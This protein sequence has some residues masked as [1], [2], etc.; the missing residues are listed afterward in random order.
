MKRKYFFAALAFLI[1]GSGAVWLFHQPENANPEEAENKLQSIK[2]A[3]E[4]EFERTKDPALGYPPIERLLVAL[5]QTKARQAK[6]SGNMTRGPISSP[7]WHERGP[8]N[9]GGRTRVILI[10]KNDPT[11]RTIWAGGVAGGLW[12]TTDI[13]A[14]PVQWEKINDY[15][16]NMAIGAMAQDPN[17]PQIMYVGTGEGYGNWDAVQGLGLFKSTNGGA[18][19]QLLPSTTNGSF[20]QSRELIVTPQG[21]VYVCTNKG[22]HRSKDGGNTWE[23]VLGATLQGSDQTYDIVYSSNGAITA[24]TINSVYRSFTGDPNDWVK[25]SKS[26]VP[27]GLDR[28]E[29][30]VCPSDPNVIYGIGAINGGASVAFVTYD[31]GDTWFQRARPENNNGNEFTNGQAWYDL[32]IAVNPSNCEDVIT[33]GVPIRRSLD[34]ANTWQPFGQGI[35][36]DQ[37]VTVFDEEDPNRIYFGCDGGIYRV[38][39][40]N[41]VPRVEDKNFGYNVTQYYACAMHPDAYSDYFLGGTQ[42]NGSHQLNAWGITSAR[43]VWG[44]DGFMAH[45]DQNDPQIQLVSSQY[46][47]WG[48]SYNGGQSFGEGQGVNGGFFNPSDYD[49]DAKILY[50]ETNDGDFYRWKIDQALLELVD[51]GSMGSLNISHIRVDE[52]TPNRIYIG[53]NGGQVIRVDNADTGDQVVGTVLGT[54]GGNISSIDIEMGNPDHILITFSNY[55][56][57]NNIYE[58]KNGGQNWQGVEGSAVPNNL[59]DMPVRWGIFNP[60]DATQ[61]MIATEAGVWTTELLDGNQTVWIPPMPGSG[62][63][64]VRTDMLQVRASDKI[65]LA[66]THARGMFTTDVFAD[67]LARMDFRKVHYLNRP[68]LFDGGPSYGADSYAWDIGDGTTSTEETLLHTYTQLGEYPVSLTINGNLSTND[69]VKILPQRPLPYSAGGSSYGGDFEGFTEQYGV[70]HISGSSFERGKSS[71]AYKSGTKSGDNAFVV[72]MNENM[73]HNT[74]TMLYLPEFDFTEPGLYEFSFW[75]KFDLEAGRDAFR[76]EYSTNSGDTWRV[77]GEDVK[78]NWYNTTNPGLDNAVFPEGASYFSKRQ[79]DYKQFQLNISDLAG[80]DHVAFRFVAKSNASGT[81]AGLAIDDVAITRYEGELATQ[82][83][84]WAGAF[85]GSIEVTL[86]WTTLPEYFCKR[87]ELERSLNGKDFEKIQTVNATGGLTDVP[88]NYSYSLLSQRDLYFFRLKVINENTDLGYSY[89]FYSPTI[90]VRRNLEGTRVF[91]AF[92]NPFTDFVDVS[93]TDVVNGPVKYDLFDVQ[94]RLLTAGAIQIEDSAYFRAS[95]PDVASGVYF[96]RL[97]VGDQEAETVKLLKVN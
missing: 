41:G 32:E 70:Y 33:G 1:A 53:T 26:P 46:G 42:D 79:A 72:G 89:E 81:S 43:N 71:L 87:F 57:T 94:G 83:I 11:R 68:M 34:G 65:V 22:V 12:K 95:L 62:I 39:L 48:I 84:D 24:S 20:R 6:L 47:N 21:H 63:P 27:S 37:H 14:D 51:I 19:W 59:P 3:F 16:E 78:E 40:E 25:I 58:S 35:H 93:F 7:K 56:L 4:Y 36:S 77:L 88:Q 91:H 80:N 28:L 64:L 49:N 69:K 8:D 61:A 45:I 75:A 44:G 66:S 30:A 13:D 18:T 90:T 92:P 67:P 73:Q 9:I 74:N 76:V 5:E 54:F 55:G 52:N 97:Q 31:G 50:T 96:L 38:V 2:D 10:D 86:N 60:N 29:I 17:N 23:K 15:M 82:L 85:T